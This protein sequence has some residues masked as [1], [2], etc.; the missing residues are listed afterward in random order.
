MKQCP[1][2]E[3][4]LSRASDY[5]RIILLE[6]KRLHDYTNIFGDKPYRQRLPCYTRHNLSWQN[7]PD[8][9]VPLL[10]QTPTV[11]YGGWTWQT[12]LSIPREN[13]P[14][15]RSCSDFRKVVEPIADVVAHDLDQLVGK[16]VP[17]DVLDISWDSE[18]IK[19]LSVRPPPEFRFDRREEPADDGLV[20]INFNYWNY[21]S[22]T[23]ADRIATVL[24]CK[25]KGVLNTA[26]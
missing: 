24:S 15:F 4:M 7:A 5:P 26:K 9:I 17:P 25:Y 18:R 3:R 23:Y 10:E 12:N 13:R 22:D 1:C 8:A 16:E 2:C 11:E 14:Y 6:V 19:N 21:G 20:L